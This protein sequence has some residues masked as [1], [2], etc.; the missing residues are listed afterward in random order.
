MNVIVK[1]LSKKITFE[2]YLMN[3]ELNKSIQ[4]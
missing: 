3:N 2:P 4:I 1:N